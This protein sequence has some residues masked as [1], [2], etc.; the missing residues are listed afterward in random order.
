MRVTSA[1]DTIVHDF[2]SELE[3]MKTITN[4][5]AS[6]FKAFGEA[7]KISREC[8]DKLA[9]LPRHLT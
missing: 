8:V 4:R 3:I 6:L 5:A 9:K 7:K 2:T 1:S